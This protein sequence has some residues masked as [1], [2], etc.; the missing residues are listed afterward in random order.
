MSLLIDKPHSTVQCPRSNQCR[1][2]LPVLIHSRC[3]Y[4]HQSINIHF[5]RYGNQLQAHKVYKVYIPSSCFSFSLPNSPLQSPDPTLIKDST[6]QYILAIIDDALRPPKQK[7]AR[8]G[9]ITVP[10]SPSLLSPLLIP[11]TSPSLPRSSPSPDLQPEYGLCLTSNS[12]L[13]ALIAQKFAGEGSNVAINYVSNG[14]R[15]H[16]TAEK[17]E[18]EFGVKVV[19]IQGVSLVS[20]GYWFFGVG[21]GVQLGGLGWKRADG[22]GCGWFRMWVFWKTASGL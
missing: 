3:P 1:G 20:W 9:R 19:V 11:F 15:A 17:I 12:G 21:V 7:C 2:P 22:G 13:G 4:P 8:D 5:L 18:R 6:V 16:E 14:T 10:S